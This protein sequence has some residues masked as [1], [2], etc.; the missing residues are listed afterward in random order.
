ML[1][2]KSRET[3]DQQKRGELVSRSVGRQCW[4]VVMVIILNWMAFGCSSACPPPF[5][6]QLNQAQLACLAEL[7]EHALR[8]V[9]PDDPGGGLPLSPS[10]PVRERG[11]GIPEGSYQGK[12]AGVVKACPLNDEQLAP[13][14]PPE[15]LGGRLPLMQGLEGDLAY[16]LSD[17]ARCRLASEDVVRP[18]PQPRVMVESPAMWEKVAALL[19]RFGVVEKI[20]HEDVPSFEGEK[21]FQG[22]FGVVKSGRFLPDG[23]PILRLIMDCRATNAFMMKLLSDLT[24]MPGGTAL[25][26]IVLLPGETALFSAEDLVAAFYLLELP[27]A[28]R[29]YFTFRLPVDASALGGP[30]GKLVYVC[31]RVLP[32][33]FSGATAVMQHWHRRLA[34]GRLPKSLAAGLPGL[35]AE[36]EIR[37]GRPVPLSA[38]SGD[39]SAWKI[40]LD[41]FL[42]VEILETGRS[43][44]LEGRPSPDQLTLREHY[45]LSHVPRGDGKA[46]CGLPLV[47]HL[48]Y[49]GNGQKG[50]LHLSVA[51]MLE[52]QSIGFS[53]ITP[54]TWHLLHFQMFAGKAAH[55]LQLRRPLW[56]LL[57]RFWLCFRRPELVWLPRRCCAGARR[58]I[59]ALMGL[60]P[61]CAGRFK[62]AIDGCVTASDASEQGLGVSRST[63]LSRLGEKFVSE[64]V[65][66]FGRGVEV[67]PPVLDERRE[68]RL[69]L[70]SLFDGIGGIRRAAERLQLPV[71]IYVS[72]GVT[73]RP[74]VLSERRSPGSWSFL[75]FISSRVPRLSRSLSAAPSWDASTLCSQEAGHAKTSLFLTA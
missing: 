21:L 25:L 62:G 54:T 7:D 73:L 13:G 6:T 19:H 23:R 28:W 3:F 63:R 29:P 48:G 17:P 42:G 49:K 4:V 35:A 34:L 26:N 36:Q 55:A 11:R 10:D 71:P 72:A 16:Y 67:V 61:L 24:S 8:A 1:R 41:D 52:L 12:E 45:D 33:G 32:M 65:S 50:L 53:L 40:Y 59:V 22:A 75:M 64:L 69:L 2:G 20:E 47:A 38:L 14:L 27:P 5:S 57:N 43:R 58:E 46:L 68:P 39:R 51:R 74:A 44:E 18:I 70:V 66:S 9:R 30:P 37:Q 56:S 31:S 15:G 60:L